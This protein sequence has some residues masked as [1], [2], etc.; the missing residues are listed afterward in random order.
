MIP[1]LTFG[2]DVVIPSYYGKNCVTGIGLKKALY[3]RFQQPELVRT[4]GTFANGIGSCQVQWTF[5]D[6]RV[7]SEFIFQVK[8]PIS[9][10]KMRLALVIASPHSSHRL[11]T[12]LCLGGEGLR[13]KVEI[14]DFQAN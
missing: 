14:D 7:S 11:G 3:L 1:E 6:G 5:G 13:A 4:D 10:D 2:K 8:N 9:L 12:T